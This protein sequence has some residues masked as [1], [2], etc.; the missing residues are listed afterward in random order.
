MNF[1]DPKVGSAAF[2]VLIKYKYTE[3]FNNQRVGGTN[4][5]P[6]ES[7]IE[8]LGKTLLPHRLGRMRLDVGWRWE[9]PF[10]RDW[11]PW[12]RHSAPYRAAVATHG[13]DHH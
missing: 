7:L 8:S 13:V 4:S 12:L 9:G 6:Y 5:S 11:L 1:T 2:K 3:L 10:G